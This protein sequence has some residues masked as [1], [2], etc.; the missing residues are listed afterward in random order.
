MRPRIDARLLLHQNSVLVD[1]PPR[2][3]VGTLIES[4]NG[5]PV[6]ACHPILP[7]YLSGQH[8]L[9]MRFPQ[10]HPFMTYRP[11]TFVIVPHPRAC[12]LH[13]PVHLAP[14]SQ[15]APWT[16]PG[17]RIIVTRQP[18]LLCMPKALLYV[19]HSLSHLS[20]LPL[21]WPGTEA[22]RASSQ[23]EG[24]KAI[25][26]ACC[27]TCNVVLIPDSRPANPGSSLTDDAT[28]ASSSVS[29][30]TSVPPRCPTSLPN[31]F[32]S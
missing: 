2:S 30:P 18:D 10:H 13:F 28:F 21:S 16:S 9:R 15:Q 1:Y 5:R 12:S 4:S 23:G 7:V 31:D 22:K 11:A 17:L 19:F 6:R 26:V 20:I 24:V 29:E 8:P 3:D 27:S 14:A 32:T 25:F